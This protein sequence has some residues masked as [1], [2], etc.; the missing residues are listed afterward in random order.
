MKKSLFLLCLIVF[1]AF[2]AVFADD[3]KA[4]EF[5]TTSRLYGGVFNGPSYKY[6]LW[7]PLYE[8]ATVR[9]TERTRAGNWVYVERLNDD[10]DVVQAGWV[11][12][13]ILNDNPD[14]GL[15]LNDLPITDL[16]DAD[17]DL[18]FSGRTERKLYEMPILS[19]ISPAL[20]DVFAL[21][22]SLGNDPS[23]FTKIGDSLIEDVTYLNI[24][25]DPGYQLGIYRHL[26]DTV[27]WFGASAGESIS[28]QIGM[29]SYTIFDPMWADAEHC[30][31][32]ETPLDCELR[33]KKPSVAFILFGQN[34]VRRMT[35]EQFE[36]QISLIVEHLLERG[37][38]PVLSTFSLHPDDQF[39]P[40][41]MAFNGRIVDLSIKYDVP[42][43][44]LWAAAQIL[45]DYGL[46]EDLIHMRRSGFT[47]L[48][49]DRGEDMQHGISL[50][51]LLALSLL[52]HLRRDFDMDHTD[53]AE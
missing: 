25:G 15:D 12:T 13:S 39:Y 43:I 18:S 50:Q 33:L 2:S 17:M 6:G 4:Q 3:E 29:T 35:F 44:N 30:N 41:G 53:S 28:A 42:L 9:I 27:L 11:Q 20:A 36:T 16:L 31:G 45:P 8:T 5:I 47:Y 7:G 32:G 37:V 40:Q 46:D 38:I 21:G 34:D 48:K 10:G 19:A 26:E 52:D 23:A 14:S 49:F 51:N 1:S 22:Q 24:M